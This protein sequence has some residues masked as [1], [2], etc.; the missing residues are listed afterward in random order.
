[1]WWAW[2]RR[3]RR[4]QPGNAQPPSRKFSARR[5][6]SGIE[7]GAAADVQ[8][9]GLGAEDHRDDVGVA[10]PAS[11]GGRVGQGAGV[12]RAVPDRQL[13]PAVIHRDRQQRPPRPAG[14]LRAGAA[15]A[16]G[17]GRRGAGIS[18]SSSGASS[19]ASVS[20]PC[21]RTR[22]SAPASVPAWSGPGSVSASF[23]RV[24][25]TSPFGPEGVGEH[26]LE[27]ARLPVPQRAV[28]IRAGRGGQHPDALADRLGVDR[29]VDPDPHL[30]RAVRARG[31]LQVVEQVRVLI[32]RGTL[33]IEPA[34]QRVGEPPQDRGREQRR[35]LRQ[36]RIRR[37]D[38]AG[39]DVLHPV[40]LGHGA[41]DDRH[42]LRGDLPRR[43]HRRGA[44]QTRRQW[45]AL[46]RHPRSEVLGLVAP[47]GPPSPG[48]P[49]SSPAAA[50]RCC[51][52][53]SRERR[54]AGRGERSAPG[55]GSRPGG[56]RSAP[57]G[58][59]RAPPARPARHHLRSCVRF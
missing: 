46:Q 34:Q 5:I 39:V 53:R 32:R 8:R 59:R 14:G 52:P 11:D 48:R 56:P 25:V 28:V 4:V 51:D 7:P 1:M 21:R 3:G 30:Q 27:R 20:R 38:L 29:V 23:W 15:G 19:A 35:L 47:A 17:S 18:A 16:A 49:A 44:R 10:G 41:A 40:N 58:Q 13:Q 26:L 45:L 24:S 36:I 37:R 42:V 22:S 43:Q 12:Q 50:A 33:G 54:R 57:R 31:H 9:L 6:A 55:A 2:Q